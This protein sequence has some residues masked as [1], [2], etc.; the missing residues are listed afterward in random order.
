MP[1]VNYYWRVI[2]TGLS[3]SVFGIGALAITLTFFP[4][5]HLLA[6]NRRRAHKGCQYVVHLS[7]GMFIWMMKSL[8]ILTYEF[9]G[10]EKISKPAGRLIIANHPTLLD[11]VFIISRLPLTQ[12]VVK[13]AAWSNPF[14]AGVMWA[15]GYIQNEDPML[16]IE[17]CVRSLER[18]DNLVMFPESTRSVPGERMILKRGVA[19]IIATSRKSFTPLIVTCEPS[20]LTKGKKWYEIPSRPMHYKISVGEPVDPLPLIAEGEKLG[21][22]NRRINRAI[23]AIFITGVKEHGQTG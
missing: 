18:G 14:L 20:T 11:V 9:I 8:G 17:E 5:I 21:K 2:A 15:T 22:S 23:E 3:F 1:Q 19:S 6:F 12:C 13:R 10:L 16:L 7:F 4:A